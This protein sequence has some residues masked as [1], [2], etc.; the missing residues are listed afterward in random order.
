MIVIAVVCVGLFVS[1][2]LFFVCLFHIVGFLPSANDTCN[3]EIVLR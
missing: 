2:R 1:F 3:V